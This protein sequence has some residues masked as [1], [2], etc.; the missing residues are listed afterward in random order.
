MLIGLHA[1]S[2]FWPVSID[3]LNLREYFVKFSSIRYY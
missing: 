3:I 1:E 2:H